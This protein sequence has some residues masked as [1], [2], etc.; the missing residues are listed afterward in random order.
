MND[1]PKT[2]CTLKD[3]YKHMGCMPTNKDDDLMLS[4][5][6]DDYPDDENVFEI[7]ASIKKIL[8]CFIID[9]DKYSLSLAELIKSSIRD[10]NRNILDIL[11]E[12]AEF[13]VNSENP[14]YVSEAKEWRLSDTDR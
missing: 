13:E 5:L 2:V 6:I 14:N 7:N 9:P 1:Y 3:Y 4:A 8:S 11:K 12:E 10:N